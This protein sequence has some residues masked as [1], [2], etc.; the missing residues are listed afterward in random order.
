MVEHSELG[1]RDTHESSGPPGHTCSKLLRQCGELG[2]SV[3]LGGTELVD[4]APQIKD[5]LGGL[6][7]RNIRDPH[8]A[9]L[10]ARTG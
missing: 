6:F 2:C 1:S 7:R 10:R 4:E 5:G 9:L 8:H 3:E